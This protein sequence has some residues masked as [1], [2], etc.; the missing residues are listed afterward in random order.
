MEERIEVAKQEGKYLSG[1]IS[2]LRISLLASATR[3][4]VNRFNRPS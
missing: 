1:T 3:A 4:G 2:P